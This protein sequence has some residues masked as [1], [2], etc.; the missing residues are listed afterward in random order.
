MNGGEDAR[1]A[2]CVLF[3]CL[4]IGQPSSRAA[5][6]SVSQSGSQSVSVLCCEYVCGKHLSV[7]LCPRHFLLVGRLG[8]RPPVPL[9]RRVAA[10]V[11][12]MVV[13]V[14]EYGPVE[15]EVVLVSLP[16]E[17]V[18]EEAAQVGVVRAVLKAQAAAVVQIRHELEW[19]VFAEYFDG[20]G[21]FLLHDLLVLLLLGVG[22]EP[23]PRQTP[24]VEV[25]QHVTQRLQIVASRLFDSEVCVDGCVSSGAGEVLVF[26]VGDVLLRLGVAVLLGQSEIDDVH[27]LCLLAESDEEVVGLDIAMDEV[28]GVDVL[29]AVQH[30]VGEHECGFE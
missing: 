7:C 29:D 20:R 3:V 12:V 18:L 14:V 21:H 16:E 2:L 6:Q 4:L 9:V 26:A 5:E 22:L 30:L 13:L 24:T 23:L 27:N 8:K 10:A 15:D 28:L 19:E 17:E 11:L 25:H 1:H